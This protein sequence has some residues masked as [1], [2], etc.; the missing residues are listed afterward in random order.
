M[1]TQVKKT[2]WR[3]DG[4]DTNSPLFEVDGEAVDGRQLEVT[5]ENEHAY[6]ISSLGPSGGGRNSFG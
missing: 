6:R 1:C 3:Q 2:G 4:L 5:K